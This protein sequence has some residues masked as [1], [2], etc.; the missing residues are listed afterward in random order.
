MNNELIKRS[1]VEQMLKDLGGCD[2]SDKEA[3]GWDKAIDAAV[4]GLGKIESEDRWIL[5]TF[6]E[7]GRFDCKIPDKG[8]EVLLS[9]GEEVWLEVFG[10]DKEGYYLGSLDGVAWQSLPEPWKGEE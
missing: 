10:C 1:D 2:A 4:E 8:E 3:S 6:D 7:N 9:D 5:F